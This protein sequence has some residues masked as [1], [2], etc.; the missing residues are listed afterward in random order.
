MESTNTVVANAMAANACGIAR[1]GVGETEFEVE[2]NNG[3]KV[4]TEARSEDGARFDM[5][6]LAMKFGG[7]KSVT[8]KNAIVANAALDEK[9]V[10]AR[11]GQIY[12]QLELLRQELN[13]SSDMELRSKF[14]RTIAGA[15]DALDYD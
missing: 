3:M 5:Q 8:A 13:R 10:M 11:L 2:F 14:M 15:M 4:R 6:R 9:S 7:I 1:N 12:K